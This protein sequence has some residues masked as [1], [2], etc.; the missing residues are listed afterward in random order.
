MANFQRNGAISNSH[1]GRDFE[2][3]I[4][5]YCAR[6]GVKLTPNLSLSIGVGK[7]KKPHKFD[8]GD[9]HKRILVECKSH[10]WTEIR[11]HAQR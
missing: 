7:I 9:A 10:T 5:R 11:S 6:L 2:S 8:L 3:R 1:V 4:M